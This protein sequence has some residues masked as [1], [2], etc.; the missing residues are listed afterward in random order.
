MEKM[1]GNEKGKHDDGNEKGRK[2][3]NDE[4]IDNEDGGIEENEE[5]SEVEEPDTRSHYAKYTRAHKKYEKSAKGQ[6]ARSRYMNSDKGK[7]ARKRYRAKRDAENKRI[8][9]LARE[10]GIGTN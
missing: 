4:T 5:A 10:A 6:A 9:K 3:M 1:S 8:L 7:A 2:T